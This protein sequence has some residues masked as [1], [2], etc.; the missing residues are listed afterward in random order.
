MG[1]RWKLQQELPSAS[2]GQEAAELCFGVACMLLERLPARAQ[3]L[4]KSW[5]S[6]RSHTSL[7]DTAMQYSVMA[8]GSGPWDS[9]FPVSMSHAV[10]GWRL[11][12]IINNVVKF[13]AS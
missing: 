13:L 5:A 12:K 9:M 6:L 2:A 4:L 3:Q 8:S 7:L 11:L 10:P 1:A